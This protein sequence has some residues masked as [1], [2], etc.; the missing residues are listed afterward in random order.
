MSSF[1]K[2][3]FD[4]ASFDATQDKQ[5]KPNDQLEKKEREGEGFFADSVS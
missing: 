3:P 5:V 2:P 4:S 1:S